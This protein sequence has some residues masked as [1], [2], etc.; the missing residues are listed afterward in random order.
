MERLKFNYPRHEPFMGFKMVCWFLYFIV[1]YVFFLLWVSL[2]AVISRI[3]RVE[4]LQ[5]HFNW[6]HFL[7]NLC[8]FAL[9]LIG[10]LRWCNPMSILSSRTRIFKVIPAPLIFWIKGHFANVDIGNSAFH[11]IIVALYVKSAKLELFYCWQLVIIGVLYLILFCWF[12]YVFL[13]IMLPMAPV[14]IQQPPLWCCMLTV[15]LYTGSWC[16]AGTLNLIQE[17][18]SVLP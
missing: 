13:A 12:V 14:N 10:C 2:P 6:R 17:I 1:S 18:T 16:L 11:W 4:H 15:A 8:L 5:F 7:A 3:M 9:E